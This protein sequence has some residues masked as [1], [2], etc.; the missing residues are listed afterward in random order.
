MEFQIPVYDS[1]TTT[2][3][4]P[5]HF[6]DPS[7]WTK[8]ARR[9][10]KKGKKRDLTAHRSPAVDLKISFGVVRALKRCQRYWRPR[11]LFPYQV[12]KETPLIS[13]PSHSV[14]SEA[15][16]GAGRQKPREGPSLP[17]VFSVLG[18]AVLKPWVPEPARDDVLSDKH[19]PLGL[20]QPLQQLGTFTVGW[21]LLCKAPCHFYC[22][23]SKKYLHDFDFINRYMFLVARKDSLQTGIYLGFLT[24]F[25]SISLGF[26]IH[27]PYQEMGVERISQTWPVKRNRPAEEAAFSSTHRADLLV[28]P[29]QKGHILTFSL[30]CP[31]PKKPAVPTVTE[32][33]EESEKTAAEK[34]PKL[35]KKDKAN[36]KESKSRVYHS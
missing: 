20:T 11:I 19:V 7:P 25:Q 16:K 3:Q 33:Q 14:L 27:S 1:L 36:Q 15:E 22:F 31:L 2:F 4:T 35:M 24:T 12:R 21:R 8:G 13:S 29:E 26:G 10:G 5:R 32:S 23:S 30:L 28:R 17:W 34:S 9:E 6:N 18:T